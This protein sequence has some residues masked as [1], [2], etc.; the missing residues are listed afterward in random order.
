VDPRRVV[1]VS[2]YLSRHLRHDPGRLG[3]EL[4]PG[5]WVGVDEL[6]A[7]CA[8]RGFALSRT[9]LEEVV[10]RN[11]KSRFALD[12]GARRIRA[13]Q[14]HSVPVDLGLAP[15]TPPPRLFHGTSTGRV[16]AILRDGLRPMGRH[17]VHL[18]PDVATARRVGA[19]HGPPAV[20]E[21]AAGDLAAA[22]HI[23]LRSDNGVWLT[24]HVPPGGLRCITA[25]SPSLQA[26][27]PG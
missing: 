24:D 3:L 21:V 14:G 19:R 22:G 15:V 5:G 18:S 4:D 2:R 20:L 9:E 23:F 17:H 27:R 13:S 10:A 7:A 26:P 8:A 1:K 11:D 6:L 25:P 12:A 16:E